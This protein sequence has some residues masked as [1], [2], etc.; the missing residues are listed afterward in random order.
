MENFLYKSYMNQILK[1]PLM[2][3]EQ[4]IE[5]SKLIQNGD[6]EAKLRM[7]QANLRLVVSVAKK[8]ENNFVSIMD[9]IQEGN[10]GLL[11]AVNK[12]H[13][14]FNTR[15]STYAY[16]WITQ[17]ITR[18]IRNKTGAIVLPHRKAELIRKIHSA[19]GILFQ[20]LGREAT[21]KEIAE[22]LGVSEKE[23][24]DSIC[25]SYNMVSLDME[26]EDSGGQTVGDTIP[27]YEFAPENR[28]MDEVKK[29]GI[30]KMLDTL[31]EKEKE[32]LEKRFNFE[33]DEKPGTLRK[34]GD[35]MGY[36]AET[37]R[38]ME[39]RGIRHLKENF[40]PQEVCNL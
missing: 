21:N 15:F 27:D 13:Y 23:I 38:Q 6:N 7:V 19:K 36:S 5:H 25:Y 37:I 32:V 24:D 28:Y 39:L 8:Y 14:S 11:T 20:K 34:I 16:A 29:E 40:T 2:T 9:L 35:E 18:F 33:N 31:P 3:F 10:I 12:Y 26:T 1:Y 17:A 22:Q 4:E 30:R